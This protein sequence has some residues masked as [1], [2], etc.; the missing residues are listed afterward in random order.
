MDDAVTELADRVRALL[1]AEPGLEEKRMFGTRAFLLDGR[2]LVGARKEGVLLVRVTEE[3][4]ATLLTEPGVSVAVM[5]A[6]SMGPSWLD[7]AATAIESDDA[8]MFWVDA[9]RDSA[10]G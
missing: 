2:I 8:L 10:A 4:G 9:A 5:G 6:K 3:K 1:M 7:V